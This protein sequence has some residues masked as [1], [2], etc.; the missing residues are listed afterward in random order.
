MINNIARVT[1]QTGIQK[2]LKLGGILGAVGVLSDVFSPLAPFAPIFLGVGAA[3]CVGALLIGVA[4]SLAKN[5]LRIT[6]AGKAAR[7]VGASAVFTAFM[8]GVWG[9]N[10]KFS[11]NGFLGTKIDAVKAL[12]Q[13]I[14]PQLK[15]IEQKQDMIVQK[16]DQLASKQDSMLVGLDKLA[17]QLDRPATAEDS[18]WV[19]QSTR[20][21]DGTILHNAYRRDAQG[22]YQVTANFMR[23]WME[24]EV[25]VSG[26][27][28]D[29][30][31]LNRVSDLLRSNAK[32]LAYL[33]AN[34]YLNRAASEGLLGTDSTLKSRLPY[35]VGD[36][37]VL[38]D[39]LEVRRKS[40]GTRYS[41]GVVKLGVLVKSAEK[42]I[43][44][45]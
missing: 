2:I 3:I 29:T 40:D 34:E 9:L 14:M 33:R 25:A 1:I 6:M 5:G 26:N 28:A 10:T 36:A 27:A 23:G 37:K 20:M 12:Q 30:A 39:T 18:T 24:F 21:S 42:T 41:V 22:A 45:E 19:T 32:T 35:F 16:Q 43:P 4:P 7:V 17:K 31:Q 15:T 44:A 38:R 13:A 8:G 11:G